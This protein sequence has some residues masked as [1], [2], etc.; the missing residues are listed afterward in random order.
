MSVRLKGSRESITVR[1]VAWSIEHTFRQCGVR[2]RAPGT[3]ECG[4]APGALHIGIVACS[5][6]GAALCYRT[7]CSEGA[8]FLGPHNHPEVSVHTHPLA[9]YMQCVDN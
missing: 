7:L 6:E 8:Q 3:L 9:K 5:A 1:S 2:L 4:M